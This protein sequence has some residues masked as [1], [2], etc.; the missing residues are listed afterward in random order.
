LGRAD[1]NFWKTKIE[2]TAKQITRTH[3]W[4][5]EYPQMSN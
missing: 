1:G 4:L 3:A 2:K 5:K